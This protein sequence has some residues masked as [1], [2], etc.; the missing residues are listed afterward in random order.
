VGRMRPG[1]TLEQAQADADRVAAQLA[2]DFP[3]SNTDR[4]VWLFSLRDSYLGPTK[5][6]LLAV[7]AAVGLLLLIACANVVGLQLVR[8]AGRRQEIALRLAIGA[9]RSRLLQQLI[10]EGLVLAFAAAVV[11]FVVS[12]WG[13]EALT[14]LAPDGLLPN[15]ATPSLNLATFGF[16]LAVATIAGVLFGLIPARSSARV[17]LVGS[18]KEGSRGSAGGFGRMRL[19]PQQLLVITETAV[20]LILLVGAGLFVRSLQQQLAVSP[21]FDARGVLR[22]RL[23]LPQRY[24]PETRLQ[25]AEQLHTRLSA[26]PSVKAVAIGSD[27]PLGG[28]SSAAFIHVPDADQSVRFYR[29]SVAPDFFSALGIRLVSGRTF[30]PSD[31]DGAPA[32]VTINESMAKRFWPNESAV[33]KRLRLGEKT[34]PEV[35]VVGVMGDV[36]YR[37]LTTPLATSEP[38]VYFP[39]AQ[40]PAGGLQ[41]AL[42]SDLSAESITSAVRRELA[43]IDPSIPLFGVRPLET[44]L[45]Q[46]TARGRFASS[47]LGVFG[48]AALVLTAVGLYGVLAFLVSLRTKEIGIR[49]ALGASDRRVLRGVISHGLK[50][51]AIGL[52]I[53]LL[54]ASGAT[55][56]IA[57]QLF[58]VGAHDP[59]VFIAVPA[60]L[61]GVAVLASWVPA[62]RASQVDPQIALR[63]D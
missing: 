59:V 63:S 5:T 53:G 32:V 46:Q 10:V 17:D 30:T 43:A 14:T 61:L 38:D 16:T 7:F 8:A 26:I 4:G 62:W 11:G 57:S 2:N 37:D 44:L 12:Y 50:L 40:R 39:I 3:Q 33:G 1:V 49:I 35:T 47:I 58:A 45:A 41:I 48:V 6:L 21:G 23:V 18:L 27:L 55:R 19:G 28:S 9:D 31:R 56:W 24:T 29:H 13:V 20:A 54:V 22:A 34:G 25:L 36:R 15:Y 42:R 51:V 60:L 52:T